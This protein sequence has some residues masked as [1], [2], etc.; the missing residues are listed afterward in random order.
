MWI[1][2][3]FKILFF[4]H[5]QMFVAFFVLLYWIK[6]EDLYCVVFC[7]LLLVYSSGAVCFWG[8]EGFIIT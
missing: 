5:L 2:P 8:K 1:M 6:K 7:I 4:L 3:T